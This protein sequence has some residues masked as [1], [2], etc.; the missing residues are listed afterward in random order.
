MDSTPLTLGAKI[1][2]LRQ[3]KGLTQGELTRGEITPGLIS[4]I[5]S[6]RIAPS[7]RVISLLAEQLGV[8]PAEIMN[9][10]EARA[11]Q[12]QTLRQARELLAAARGAEAIALLTQ[13]A[14]SDLCYIPPMELQVDLAYGRRLAGEL[15]KAEALY[16]EVEQYAL[17]KGDHMLGHI[18]MSRLGELYY[19][20][21][22]LSLAAYAY[23]KA[24][25]FAYELPAGT[26][27]PL[28]PVE[29]NLSICVYRLGNSELALTYAKQAYE[30]VSR[31]EE[32]TPD[33]AE[34]CHI[35]SV[36]FTE[37]GMAGQG[38]EMAETAVGLY[39]KLGMEA[40]AVDAKL[41]HAIVLRESGNHSGALDL[42]PSVI[43]DYYRLGRSTYLANAWAE[44]A[45]CELA[46][47]S[48]EDAARS[49]ERCFPLTAADS[50]ETIEAWRIR[51]LIATASGR[52][53]EAAAAFAKAQKLA[54][55]LDLPTTLR[56]IAQDQ[57]HLFEQSGNEEMTESSRERLQS[58]T[59]AV[60]LRRQLAAIIA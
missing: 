1:R 41:N 7:Y 59:A 52:P 27:P 9:D 21:G 42:L 51:G 29:K 56:Q 22:D 44:R 32:P 33:L 31:L 38:G 2:A 36:L 39:R 26:T 24:L 58:L 46:Q 40:Q 55:R 37:L 13:L 18:A 6:D 60:A 19:A 35:L 16:E 45:L 48:L 25:D 34:T 15:E 10:V 30:E 23:R 17:A 14:E 53:P 20:Q 49:V 43:A 28:Y 57:L 5:E 8:E 47:G 12:L 54:E 3:A 50:P 4:Q 11:S